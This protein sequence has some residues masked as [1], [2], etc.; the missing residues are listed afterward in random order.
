MEGLESKI[1][2]RLNMPD[3]YLARDLGDA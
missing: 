2:T 1:M 3:P